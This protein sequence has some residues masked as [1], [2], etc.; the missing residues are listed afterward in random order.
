MDYLCCVANKLSGC[1][2]GKH[3]EVEM[4]DTEKLDRDVEN[5]CLNL[6]IDKDNI[7]VKCLTEQYF[8]ESRVMT[9]F[10]AGGKICPRHRDNQGVYWRPPDRCVSALVG[11]KCKSRLRIIPFN[12]M[13]L[14]E[15]LNKIKIPLGTKLCQ[16]H[17]KMLSGIIVILNFTLHINNNNYNVH[18]SFFLH[19][20]KI[21]HPKFRFII[22][23]FE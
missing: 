7:P 16:T 8:L 12:L 14:Y 17:Y 6:K 9:K 19:F 22:E 4:T 13:E 2:K 3:G 11:K 15:D 18:L 21:G 1:G 5:H 20:I 10:V 23:G